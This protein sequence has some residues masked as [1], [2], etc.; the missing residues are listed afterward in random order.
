M[1]RGWL[2]MGLGVPLMDTTRAHVELGWTPRH[3]AADTLRE[4]VDGILTG[5]GG[6][7]PVLRPIRS[8]ADRVT[9]GLRALTGRGGRI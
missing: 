2:E 6:P 5:R 3:D 1:D 9:G 8:V 7:T 4:A